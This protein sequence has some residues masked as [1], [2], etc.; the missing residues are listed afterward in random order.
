MAREYLKD[1]EFLKRLDEMRI[2]EHYVKLQIFNFQEKPLREIQGIATAGNI[3]VNG[4]SAVRRTINLTMLSLE[5]ENDLSNI[6][7]I[8]SSNKKIKVELGIKNPFN[9]YMFYGDIIWFPIGYFLITEAQSSTS[10]TTAT[11]TIKGKDKMCLLDGTVGGVLPSTVSFHEGNEIDEN[12][13]VTITPIPIFTIIKECVTFYGQEQESNIIINDIEETAK[14]SVQYIG[15]EPVWFDENFQLPPFFGDTP[16]KESGYNRKFI[17]GQDVGYVET[18][19]TFPGELVFEAGSTVTEVLDKIIQTLGNYE[20]FYDLD[21]RFIFQEKKNY[22]NHY[23]TPITEIGDYYYIKAFSDTKYHSVFDNAKSSISYYL[24]PKYDNLKNDF[25][26]W[27][28]HTD[29]NGVT[30]NIKY[31]LAIDEKPVIDLAGQ[32]MWDACDGNGKHMFYVFDYENKRYDEQNGPAQ[33]PILLEYTDDVQ[34]EELETYIINYINQNYINFVSRETSFIIWLKV[35][36]KKQVRYYYAKIVDGQLSQ[37]IHYQELDQQVQE[38]EI[39]IAIRRPYDKEVFVDENGN[40]IIKPSNPDMDTEN[41][42]DDG[43]KKSREKEEEDDSNSNNDTEEENDNDEFKTEIT[44]KKY[45]IKDKNLYSEEIFNIVKKENIEKIKIKI[46]FTRKTDVPPEEKVYVYSKD[47]KVDFD[48]KVI[49]FTSELPVL[50]IT[51][52]ILLTNFK[53]EIKT[54]LEEHFTALKIT[55]EKG[56]YYLGYND[57]NNTWKNVYEIGEKNNILLKNLNSLISSIASDYVTRVYLFKDFNKD[58]RYPFQEIATINSISLWTED[59]KPQILKVGD[60]EAKFTYEFNTLSWRDQVIMTE[61]ERKELITELV[62]LYPD[63]ATNLRIDIETV[64]NESKGNDL[65]PDYNPDMDTENKWEDQNQQP[66]NKPLENNKE[67]TDSTSSFMDRYQGWQDFLDSLI[68]GKKP[69]PENPPSEEEDDDNSEQEGNKPENDT[70]GVFKVINKRLADLIFKYASAGFT[71][72]DLMLEISSYWGNVYIERLTDKNYILNITTEEIIDPNFDYGENIIYTL[73]GKPC[74][75]WREELYRQALLN[76]E[77][78]SQSGY[79]DSE[80]LAFWR[81]NF[82]TMNDVWKMEWEDIF[83]TIDWCGWN[84]AIYRDPGLLVYWLDFLDSDQIV[85]KYSVNQI[86]RRTKAIAKDNIKMLYKLEVPD[87]MFFK[88]ESEYNEE[89]LSYYWQCG[90]KYCALKANEMRYFISSATGSTAFDLI[91]EMLYQYL[92]YNT[93]VTIN[94]IP[95]YYLEPNNVVYIRDDKSNIIGDYIITQ[96]T[97]PLTYNGTMSISC[98]Q[99]LTRV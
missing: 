3:T 28:N 2:R 8:I 66:G 21:G 36:W 34:E 9:D 12:G 23:Y 14:Q 32:Y 42:W 20:Y 55:Q 41:K 10:A 50:E 13:N 58:N 76:S 68:N 37:L 6:D 82:D 31:H 85:S 51:N 99:T 77:N 67:T 30:N 63:K 53:K 38:E 49:N 7:N 18:D 54:F 65:L 29:S 69:K 59:A 74:E 91:R 26:V 80:L 64:Y 1:V 43:N 94:C 89:L 11:I 95:K 79:Y 83:D 45:E 5:S 88:N 92:S 93:S 73:I 35:I 56:I 75:E 17:Y 19:F 47:F 44:I 39:V 78:G 97:V 24:A 33:E 4:S 48:K 40:P 90:Q 96:Y 87:V 98:T 70:N 25:V 62:K 61:E 71:V 86:G 15:K 52:I 22:L 72:N 60:D 81:T 57:L 27:G 46:R 16:D 84:P